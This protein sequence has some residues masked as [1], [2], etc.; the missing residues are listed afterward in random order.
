MVPSITAS[1]CGSAPSSSSS[2][3]PS[4]FRSAFGGMLTHYSAASRAIATYM[5]SPTIATAAA[6][7]DVE[8]TRSTTD[9]ED[10]EGGR[11]SP[12]T[13]GG[14]APSSSAQQQRALL[15]AVL[16]NDADQ[17]RTALKGGV[18]PNFAIHIG[19]TGGA[20][21]GGPKDGG[22]HNY[23]ENG[24][25][26]QEEPLS[27]KA[28][29][30]DQVFL[31][32]RMLGD[33]PAPLH[34]AIL[35]VYYCRTKQQP[36]PP[37][38]KSSSRYLAGRQN[39]THHAAQQRQLDCAMAILRLLLE[40]GADIHRPSFRPQPSSSSSVDGGM[41]P[42]GHLH[43]H[44]PGENSTTPIGLAKQMHRAAIIL[45]ASS[46]T[47]ASTAPP[48]G[49]DVAAAITGE[50]DGSCVTSNIGVPAA[51]NL[52]TTI[53]II[54][55]ECMEWDSR[56]RGAAHQLLVPADVVV[57]ADRENIPPTDN[58]NDD[59]DDD[60]NIKCPPVGGG[61]VY[62]PSSSSPQHDDDDNTVALLERLGGLLFANNNNKR[63]GSFSPRGGGVVCTYPTTLLSSSTKS[64]NR[65]LTLF[66]SD[67]AAFLG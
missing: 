2:P 39:V 41:A 27:V 32:K 63:I 46:A 15:S 25:H 4:S 6:D 29:C 7:Y 31:F 64:H 36:C 34:I 67:A 26:N 45:E 65:A 47:A 42:S 19:L 1:S 61:T 51:N 16:K 66:C 49:G 30:L 58:I 59:D 60:D 37:G 35:N 3:P 12:P 21:G 18:D 23:D 13:C 56:H 28:S 17:V 14:A 43:H 24:C 8:T 55:E 62:H 20:S 57:A 44:Q 40:H 33:S 38:R 53:G 50:G 52:R 48:P 10:D 11:D 54:I 9:H 5:D 22:G